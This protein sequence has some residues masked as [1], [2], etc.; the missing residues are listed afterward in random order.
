MDTFHDPRTASYWQWY[1][2]K[3]LRKM[4]SQIVLR[5]YSTWDKTTLCHM[6]A[7]LVRK[8]DARAQYL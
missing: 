8:G 6:L 2:L 7:R 4:A 5:G 3:D 1:T